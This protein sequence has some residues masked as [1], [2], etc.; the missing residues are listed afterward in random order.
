MN[1][2]NNEQ[3][4]QITGGDTALFDIYIDDMRKKYNVDSES[5]LFSIYMTPE[6]K[7]T[8]THLLANS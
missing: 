1:K 6:E 3:L 8:A 7:E 5:L 4:K 2:L